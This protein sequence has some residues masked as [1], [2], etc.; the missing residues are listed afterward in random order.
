M[1]RITTTKNESG[2][3][4]TFRKNNFTEM[5]FVIITARSSDI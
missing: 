2:K 5:S 4:T 3:Q 1:L